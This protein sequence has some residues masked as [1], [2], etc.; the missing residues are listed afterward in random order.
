MVISCLSQVSEIRLVAQEGDE[1][2]PR[3]LR[4]RR[5][6]PRHRGRRLHW[7]LPP[8][9]LIIS[10]I[11]HRLLLLSDLGQRQP[12]GLEGVPVDDGVED[13][14]RVRPPDAGQGQMEA[15]LL[16]LLLLGGRRDYSF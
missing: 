5:S 16:L 15:R 11:Q 13:D 3:G 6:H 10:A 8:L 9:N 1:G 4:Q 14:D 7:I 2:Q 12:R